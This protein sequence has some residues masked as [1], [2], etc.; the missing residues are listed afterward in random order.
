MSMSIKVKQSAVWVHFTKTSNKKAFCKICKKS[1]SIKGGSYGNLSRHLKTQHHRI[2]VKV[3]ASEIAINNS[4]LS[5]SNGQQ[6]SRQETL[7][8][9]MQRQYGDP[10]LVN[11]A[12]L[13]DND[14]WNTTDPDIQ[15]Y[16]RFNSSGLVET[17]IK[18]EAEDQETEDTTTTPVYLKRRKIDYQSHEMTPYERTMI[19][20]V[21]E[22]TKTIERIAT[23]RLN[24]LQRMADDNASYHTKMLDLLANKIQIVNLPNNVKESK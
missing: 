13:S 15:A 17:E 20:L 6:Q 3:P 24:V 5:T 18:V 19:K 7:I 9:S 23:K 21:K 2:V 11:E 8:A 4:S 1:L 16:D 14:D 10:L 12:T 22:R